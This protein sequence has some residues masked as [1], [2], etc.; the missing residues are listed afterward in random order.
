MEPSLKLTFWHLKMDGWNISFLLGWPIFRR[1]LLVL[2]SV[3]VFAPFG[4]MRSED[5]PINGQI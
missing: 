5:A 1:E 4:V 2:G 3:F